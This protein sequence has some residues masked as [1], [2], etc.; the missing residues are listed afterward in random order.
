MEGFNGNSDYDDDP[1]DD[2]IYEGQDLSHELQAIC[3][4]LNIHVRGLVL[5]HNLILVIFKHQSS[6][7]FRF[8]IQ[9]SLG[10]NDPETPYTTS[11]LIGLADSDPCRVLIFIG[12]V[13]NPQDP[14]R[15][16]QL[17]GMGFPS[18][19]LDE[20][21]RKSQPLPEG[22]TTDPKDSGG[23]VQP[24]DKG[25]PSTVSDECT[26]KTT[27]LPEG[28]R[29]DKDLEGLKPHADMKPLINHVADLLWTDAK[30]HADQTQ[31]A[32]L[33]YRSLTENK[34]KT[35]FEVEPDSKTLQLKT[36]ADV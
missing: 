15:N 22:T 12:S 30:F 27:T 11:G 13:P 26:V 32:R 4:N 18:T 23:N 9:A 7:V 25:L 14:E 17:V 33:M 6:I 28:P 5:N 36:F 16:I 8:S 2:D 35:S 24:A 1:C 3:D 20:G 19:Q 31:S 21:T 34:G 10:L 29:R